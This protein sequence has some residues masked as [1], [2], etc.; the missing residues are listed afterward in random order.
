MNSISEKRDAEYLRLGAYGEP[1]IVDPDPSLAGV[2]LADK[3]AE[4][5]DRFKLI[6]PLKS[7]RLKPAGYELA[8]GDEYYLEGSRLE[9]GPGESFKI[10]PF[11]VAILKTEETVNLPAFLIARWNI[12]VRWAYQGLLWVGGPQVDPQYIGHLFC[13]IYNLSSKDV[14]LE[15][16]AEIALIDFTKTTPVPTNPDGKLAPHAY[17]RPPKRVIIEDYPGLESAHT[18]RVSARLDTLEQLAKELNASVETKLKASEGEVRGSLEK[19]TGRVDSFVG[20]VFTV[21]GLLLAV[22]ALFKADFGPMPKDIVLMMSIGASF[23]TLLIAM[24]V[25]SDARIVRRPVSRILLFVVALLGL[26]LVLFM[27]RD[28]GGRDKDLVVQAQV[29]VAR[30][31]VMISELAKRVQSLEGGTSIP[32]VVPTGVPSK[33]ANAHK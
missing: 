8:V 17:Q 20:V 33:G 22:L 32:K 31:S 30:D 19:L 29:T 18:A 9:L 27:W 6:D 26:A 13:P 28:I 1:C 21:L 3:I 14:V 4:Y 24:L 23:G 7:S 12:R 25:Q 5:S 10:P 16:G 15:R 11:Q 2:L